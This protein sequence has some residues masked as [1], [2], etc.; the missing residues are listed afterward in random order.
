MHEEISIWDMDQPQLKG[1]N[2]DLEKGNRNR[3]PRSSNRLDTVAWP[4][5]WD[6]IG[7]CN[8]TCDVQ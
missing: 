6:G 2:S 1:G 7:G 5:I 4:W 8:S 3:L